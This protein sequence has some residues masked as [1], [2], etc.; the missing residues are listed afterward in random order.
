MKGLLAG[1]AMA[2]VTL[3]AVPQA[4]AGEREQAGRGVFAPHRLESLV[5]EAVEREARSK[6]QDTTVATP[7]KDSVLDGGLIGAAIGGLAVP[8]LIIASSGGTDDIQRAWL[9]VAPVPTIAGFAI[10]AIIDALR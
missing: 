2:G 9:R 5:R 6:P 7:K 8:P 4:A 3:S 1:L 10:G